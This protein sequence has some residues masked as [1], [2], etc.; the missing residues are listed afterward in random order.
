LKEALD[1][2]VESGETITRAAVVSA[3]Q[4][5]HTE[6]LERRLAP[7]PAPEPEPPEAVAQEASEV[8][9]AIPAAPAPEPERPHRFY[10]RSRKWFDPEPGI[11]NTRF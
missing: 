6:W 10:R 1:H 2:A 3:A 7:L 8:S 11:F 4:A 5:T 9:E